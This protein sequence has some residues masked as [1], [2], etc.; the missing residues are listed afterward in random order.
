M[1]TLLL[2]SALVSMSGHI[3]LVEKAARPKLTA[4]EVRALENR[5]SEQ[6]SAQVQD[7]YVSMPAIADC[8]DEY[9]YRYTGGSLDDHL[10]KFRLRT[11]ET[12]VPGRQ[13]P[14]LVWFHGRGESGDDNSRQLAH[15]Q[16]AIADLAGPDA[17]EFFLLATQCPGDNPDW[18]VHQ[19]LADGKGDSPMTVLREI[20]E[21]VI[22]GFPVDEDCI[23]VF[24]LS[25]GGE[26]A[27][28]F[29]VES[30]ERFAALATASAVPPRG[31]LLTE[32][33]VWAF[34]TR[35]DQRVPFEAV[36]EVI[37]TIN[38]N[39]GL[40]FLTRVDVD[41]HDSWTVAL[42][43]QR[44]LDWLASQKRGSLLNAPPGRNE[45]KRLLLT[46]FLLFGLPILCFITLTFVISR[47]RTC[48]GPPK[49]C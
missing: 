8:F 32:M 39:G 33:N 47:S 36:R 45:R 29:V 34:C 3:E 12:L 22:T 11:P 24:G 6:L 21:A 9:S 46:T 40:A 25:S 28:H 19:S 35:Q 13:Y 31:A 30:P 14:L 37:D 49:N 10:I 27:W 23:S 2:L 26:A 17:Q 16:T 43:D 18:T 42:R 41:G 4:V 44:V 20:M 1:Q 7:G 38:T 5:P 15:M 48:S